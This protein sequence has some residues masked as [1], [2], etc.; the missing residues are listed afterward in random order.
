MELRKFLGEAIAGGALI[1]GGLGTA[2]REYVPR[3]MIGD[4]RKLGELYG[5]AYA[6]AYQYVDQRVQ[7]EQLD[8]EKYITANAVPL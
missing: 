6:E 2:D 7:Q 5:I 8:L 1:G 4:F 3:F